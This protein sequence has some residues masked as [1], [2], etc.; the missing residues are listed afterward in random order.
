MAEVEEPGEPVEPVDSKI[1]VVAVV[2][3]VAASTR[4]PGGIVCKERRI[5]FEQRE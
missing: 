2:E 4:T 1:V 5:G 3:A